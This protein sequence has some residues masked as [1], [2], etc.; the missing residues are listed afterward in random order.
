VLEPDAVLQGGKIKIVRQLF[1]GGLSAIYLCQQEKK[2]LVVLKE[3]VVPADSNDD[4]KL[5]AEE[6]FA[7]EAKFLMKL[8]H[9]NIVKVLDHFVE[10]GR[11]YL[12]LEH[13]NGLDLRQFVIKNGA[14]PEYR[15]IEWA[16]KLAEILQYLHAQSPAIL[17]RDLTPDNIVLEENQFVK[18]IDFG[19]AN[20]FIGT[21]TGTLIGKQSYL[22]ME[23]LRGKALP[24]S[25]IYA[26]GC[27][28][29]FLLTGQDPEP[30]S[31]SR[32]KALRP[33]IS[34]ELDDFVAACTDQDYK[35][36]PASA[37][38]IIELLAAKS[39]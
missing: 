23:Q 8:D 6:L 35:Q 2:D 37:A 7:R 24:Q 4:L 22:P 14:Q 17:H 11:N 27:T 12:L 9:P 33:E 19:A 31:V 39:A 25:D 10:Q 15:V 30:L 38:A 3:S 36:R 32:P 5:K 20:E 18:V 28:L 16:L 1:F 13:I 29:H 26:L 21:A 34:T